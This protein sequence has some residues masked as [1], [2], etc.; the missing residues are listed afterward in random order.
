MQKACSL[1]L[2]TEW[3]TVEMTFAEFIEMKI[4]EAND[5]ACGVT[6]AE[7]CIA[8][9]AWRAGKLEAAQHILTLFEQKPWNFYL[10]LLAYVKE[11]K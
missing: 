3:R 6:D 1:S 9:D 2:L 10:G 5:Y 11:L 4:K 8:E 7:Q